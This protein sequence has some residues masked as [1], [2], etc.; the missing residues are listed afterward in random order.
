MRVNGLRPQALRLGDRRRVLADPLD[1][2]EHRLRVRLLHVLDGLLVASAA[3]DASRICLFDSV[4]AVINDVMSGMV[5][6][7]GARM[8]HLFW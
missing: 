1:E 8:K 5:A 7:G 6:F 3:T 4:N 2:G